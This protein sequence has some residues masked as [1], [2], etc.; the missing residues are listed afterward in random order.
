MSQEEADLQ[1]VLATL[2]TDYAKQLPPKLIDLSKATQNAIADPNTKEYA[3][4]LAHKLRG[5]AGSYGFHALSAAAGVLEDLLR[6][7]TFSSEEVSRALHSCLDAG[8]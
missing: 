6:S 7:A 3:R 2:R 5:T 1:K 8:K 4:S